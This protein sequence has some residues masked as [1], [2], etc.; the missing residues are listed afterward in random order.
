MNTNR[1]GLLG[2]VMLLTLLAGCGT[3]L[4]DRK[5]EPAAQERAQEQKPT[6]PVN[7]SGYSPSFKQGYADG[8]NSAESR[9]QRRNESRYK[10]ETDYMMGW[11][12][13]FS[14]CQRRR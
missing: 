7:L 8:C 6:A 13:G 9:S 14:I 11:N 12:D 3:A 2:A 10:S 4:F 5:S 1:Q